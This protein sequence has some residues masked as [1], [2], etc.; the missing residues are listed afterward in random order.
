MSVLA[1]NNG[2]VLE[3]PLYPPL[4][5]LPLFF[6]ISKLASAYGLCMEVGEDGGSFRSLLEG[7]LCVFFPVPFEIWLVAGH[8][9]HPH[10][11]SCP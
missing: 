2:L 3:A 7:F 10:T 1:A 11:S 4:E 6:R 8:V 5:F 9:H